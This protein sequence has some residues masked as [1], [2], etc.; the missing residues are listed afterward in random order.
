MWLVGQDA[1]LHDAAVAT[2]SSGLPDLSRYRLAVRELVA[3][4]G[5]DAGLDGYRAERIMASA[6]DQPPF[7]AVLAA[8][9]RG[10]ASSA[11]RLLMEI[12]DY[13]PSQGSA[14]MSLASFARISMLAQIDTMWWGSSPGF[15]TDSDVLESAELVDLDP[16]Q[17]AGRLRFRYRHQADT[18]LTRATRSAQRHTLPGRMPS[19][20]GLALARIRPQAVAWL[21]QLAAEF[22]EIAPPDTPP[23]WVNSLTRSIKHQRHLRSLGYAALLPSSHCV[24][25]AADIE[26]TW[27]RRFRAHRILRGLLLDH[28]RAD[29]VNVIDEGQAWHIC[30][31]PGIVSGPRSVPRLRIGG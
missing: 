19:T 13:Q 9:P 10:Q 17:E 26:I 2:W 24:G 7:A 25:F 1:P 18:L 31:H 15:Q 30:L 14:A 21:N 23:L 27:Y 16:L 11:A 28:Q 3:Q 29:E 22:A 20:A 8:C 4:I 12:R 6:L 5:R